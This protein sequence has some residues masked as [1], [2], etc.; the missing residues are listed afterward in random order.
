VTFADGLGERVAARLARGR[1]AAEARMGWANG[2]HASDAVVKR[3]DTDNPQTVDGLEVP[4][5]AVVHQ[6]LAGRLDGSDGTRT[7]TV[8]QTEVQVAV[9]V[10]K[11]PANTSDLIEGDVI[12]ITA[13]ENAGIFLRVVEA[14]WEDQA[15]QRRVPVVETQEPEGWSA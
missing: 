13:G 8:G 14:A 5:W 1:A 2:N 9:R 15:I 3:E 7:I 10:W 12:Q 4:K 6:L 11:C